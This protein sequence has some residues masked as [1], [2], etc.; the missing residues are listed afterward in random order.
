MSGIDQRPDLYLLT[1]SILAPCW[2]SQAWYPSLY[3]L[4]ANDQDRM[5]KVTNQIISLMPD[6]VLIQEAQEDTIPL[7]KRKLGQTFFFHF[8]SNNPT[9]ASIANGLLT[10][11][12][13]DW[14]YSSKAI[15]LDDI[16]DP[17]TGEAIQIMT[18]PSE[19]IH[20]VNLHL[21]YA[22]GIYQGKIVKDK[23][24]KMLNTVHPVTIMAGDLNATIDDVYD[25]F[26]WN[27]FKAIFRE[28]VED[29][30]IA[31]YYPDPSRISIN[32]A[33]DHIFYNPLQIKLIDSGKAWNNPNASVKDA[34]TQL[35]SDHIYIW[36]TFMFCQSSADTTQK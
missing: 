20:I 29:I 22:N 17:E 12:R 5:N 4:A 16:L 14:T 31:T 3:E 27:N 9:S 6:V 33:I 21:D 30:Q 1:W 8:T 36:A 34:L 15:V 23:C 35:G 2:V 26:E 25:R 18:I 32:T 19:N 11:I 28:S 7:L 13:M 24:Q 10:L